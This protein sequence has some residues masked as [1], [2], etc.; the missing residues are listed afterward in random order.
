MRENSDESLPQSF[1]KED[2]RDSSSSSP[3]ESTAPLQK[4]SERALRRKFFFFRLIAVFL[5]LLISALTAELVLRQKGYIWRIA[6]TSDEPVVLEYDPVLGWQSKPGRHTG[7]KGQKITFTIWPDNSRATQP[8]KIKKDRRIVFI[9]DS[10]T[11]GWALS[12][13]ETM[14]WKLQERFPSYEFVN[15]GTGGYGTYQSLLL[16]ERVLAKS[17]PVEA[18]FYGFADYQELRSVAPAWWLKM[19]SIFS[20]RGHVALPYCTI[21]RKNNIVRHAPESYPRWVTEK[22]PA[23]VYFFADKYLEVR[24]QKRSQQGE[25]VA[26]R[27]IVEM[28]DACRKKGV[29]FIVMVLVEGRKGAIY[30]DFFKSNNLSFVDFTVLPY[31]TLAYDMHPDGETN[32]LW[33]ECVGKYIEEN[34]EGQKKMK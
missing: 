24:A 19:L 18:V 8:K 30:K 2:T 7:Y 15:Y 17:E 5:A 27:L 28:N 34:M 33:A 13:N 4:G 25:E 26:K 1:D 20:A 23:L 11:Q 10:I 29:K 21:D 3:A 32:A 31:K 6:N 22:S 16:L 14:A 9:G 12:D